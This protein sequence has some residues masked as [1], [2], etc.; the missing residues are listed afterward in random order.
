[1]LAPRGGPGLRQLGIPRSIY[2]GAGEAL[3]A[4]PVVTN[5]MVGT[6]ISVATPQVT[7][8]DRFFRVTLRPQSSELRH[9]NLYR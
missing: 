1:M 7:F 9:A 6:S 8:G 2:A 5:R 4:E 3:E